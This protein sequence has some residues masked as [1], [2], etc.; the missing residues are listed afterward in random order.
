MLDQMISSE[1]IRLSEK[2]GF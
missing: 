2:P 1:Y